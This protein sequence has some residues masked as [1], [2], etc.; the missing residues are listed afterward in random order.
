MIRMMPGAGKSRAVGNACRARDVGWIGRW[1]EGR[2][3]GERCVSKRVVG[4]RWLLGEWV[5]RR[6]DR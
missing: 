2:Y 3:V 4:R 1:M 6:M 5:D